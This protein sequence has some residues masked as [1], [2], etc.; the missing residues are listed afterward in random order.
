MHLQRLFMYTFYMLLNS[1]VQMRQCLVL[2][3][4]CHHSFG[5][6]IGAHCWIKRRWAQSYRVYIISRAMSRN[7]RHQ[8]PQ[9]SAEYRQFGFFEFPSLYIVQ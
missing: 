8:K 2:P 5:M 7:P 1:Y 3:I 9:Y 4:L 6:W